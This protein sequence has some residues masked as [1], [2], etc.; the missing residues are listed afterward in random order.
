LSNIITV[1][2]MV[3]RYGDFT[4]VNDISFTVQEGDFFGFLGPNGAGKTTSMRIL[5]TLLKMTS[6]QATVAGHDVNKNP[7]GVR[8][9]IGFAMQE[10]SLDNLATG[11]ENLQLLGVLYGL[12]PRQSRARAGEL[13]EVVG[14]TK[15]ADQFV[16]KYSGGMRRRLDL[17]GVLMHSP[18]VLFLDEPTQG[19][20]PQARRTIWDY[21]EELNKKGS[22]IFLTTHYM[23]EA[24]ILCRELAFIDKGNIVKQG[25]PAQLKEEI[26]GEL[27]ILKFAPGA[28]IP[29]I[30]QV[31]RETAAANISL[32]TQDQQITVAAK[33]AEA[34]I[35]KLIAALDDAHSSPIS[36]SM[37]QPSL[38]DVFVKL[39]GR[40]ILSDDTSGLIEGRDPFIQGRQ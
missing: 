23:D 22:T 10:I 28:N 5:A 34:L 27:I 20:D 37:T 9:S 26:G 24:D 33:G 11:W 31:I 17:A 12:T 35:P 21:L 1:E 32:Q 13:L 39:V 16:N 4:A 29:A 19:L 14:L 25:T 3:K 40:S 30:E 18:A 36:L 2:H 38:E 15:V 6:G 7:N 8:R